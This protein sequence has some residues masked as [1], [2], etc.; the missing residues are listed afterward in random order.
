MSL[1]NS[2]R[3]LAYALLHRKQLEEEMDEELRAHIA[4]RTDDLQRSGMARAEAERQARIEFGGQQRFKEECRE[5]SGTHFMES[6][7]QDLRFGVRML[8][9]S[10]GFTLV[11]VLT[12][13]LGIG[14]NT[15]IFSYV[16][17]WLIKPLPYQ[18]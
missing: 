11:A 7:L 2:L 8:R 18:Q 5:A 9:K 17:A 13:A 6:M 15:A 10:P 12:L 4:E 16:N 1:L 3:S 14:T